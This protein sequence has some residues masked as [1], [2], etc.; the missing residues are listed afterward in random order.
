[1]KISVFNGW[2]N[3]IILPFLKTIYNGYQQWYVK[4]HF[5]SFLSQYRKS[6]IHNR[7]EMGFEKPK[8]IKMVG[9][10][11]YLIDIL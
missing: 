5:F 2:E 3:M 7:L 1:M 11:Q 4:Y 8:N 10:N 9:K 6:V